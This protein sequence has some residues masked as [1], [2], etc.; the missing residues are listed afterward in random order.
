MI[1]FQADVCSND[2]WPILLKFCVAPTRC[3]NQGDLLLGWWP[4]LANDSEQLNEQARA[5]LAR[6]RAPG[7][8]I[9]VIAGYPRSRVRAMI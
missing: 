4:E 1:V 2:E 7:Q 3:V 8:Q 5:A 9:P 6:T